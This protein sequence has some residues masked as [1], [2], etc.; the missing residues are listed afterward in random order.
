MGMF[1]STS[2]ASSFSL[3]SESTLL[4]HTIN[5]ISIEFNGRCFFDVKLISNSLEQWAGNLAI[6]E[7]KEINFKGHAV[8]QLCGCLLDYCFI[9]FFFFGNSI[10]NPISALIVN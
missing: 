1:F 8:H 6:C 10:A 2:F 5:V 3:I 9:D 4:G 7:G